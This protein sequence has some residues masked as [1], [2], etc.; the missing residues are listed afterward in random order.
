M[1]GL[2]YIELNL[3]MAE[4]INNNFIKK[5]REL[6]IKYNVNPDYV[7]MEVTES[8]EA[9]ELDV[10]NDN[11]RKIS[12]MGFKLSLDDYGTG[13]SN[14]NRFRILPISIVKIDKSLVDE[15]ENDGIKKILDYSFGLV[16]DLN[17]QT[18]VEGVETKEQFE[19]FK[20]YGANYIQGFYF[21]KPLDYN[22]YIEFVSNNN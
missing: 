15:S 11:L 2:D 21:S 13:Y 18:V 8:F 10:I 4:I 1:L 6:M 17:K 14:I 9:S 20:E 19:L 7:N 12:E 5:I 22:R 3:S 16:K